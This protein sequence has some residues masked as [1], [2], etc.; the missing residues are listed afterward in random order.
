MKTRLFFVI[1]FVIG[2]VLLATLLPAS[3]ISVSAQG[4]KPTVT[5]RR[6][7][8]PQPPPVSR[9]RRINPSQ[10]KPH[11]A[12]IVASFSAGDVFAGVA[13]GQ[14]NWY[15]A[16]GVLAT[17]LDTG[18]G[19]FTTGMAFDGAG[20]LYVTNFSAGTVSKFD[21]SGNYL[22]IFGSG[23]SGSPESIVFDGAGNAY[24]GSVD[25]DDAI[26]KFDPAGNPLSQYY[27]ATETRGSDWIDLA[28]DQCTMYYTSEGVTVKRFNV[29]TNTQLSD[30]ASG[31]YGPDY[32][33]RILADGSVLIADT[34]QIVRLDSSG[35]IIQTYS[36]NGENCWF[37]LN[38]DPDGT[39]FWS[40]D[41][42]TGDIYRFDIG[43][44]TILLGPLSTCGSNCL[45]GLAIA[46]EIKAAT[47]K[48]HLP[49]DLAFSTS[50][51]DGTD[52]IYSYFDHQYPLER[53]DLGGTEPQVP[54]I[55]D[56][57]MIFTGQTYLDCWTQ[58]N[59]SPNN[60]R[61]Y[62]GHDGYDFSG[63][64][65]VTPVY[66]A[67]DGI[68]VAT[69]WK[70]SNSTNINVMTVTKGDVQTIYL[71]LYT[72]TYWSKFLSNPTQVTAGTR[73]G[74]IG[75]T[76]APTCSKG[77][78]LHFGV[79]YDADH[80]GFDIND[81][82]DPYSFPPN[83]TDPWTQSFQDKNGTW[84]TGTPSP[85]M[86]QFGCPASGEAGPGMSRSLSTGDA[87]VSVTS[88]ALNSFAL[89]A[90]M[91]SP[92]PLSSQTSSFSPSR[93]P[94]TTNTI[95]IGSVYQFSGTYGDG[96]PVAG[97]ASAAPLTLTY[98]NSDLSY[99]NPSTLSIYQWGG[100]NTGWVSVPT[101]VN[102]SVNQAN[103]NLSAPGLFSLRAQ[104]INPAP[105]LLSVSPSSA[106]NSRPT[107]ITITGMNFMSTPW[108]NLGISAL[109]VQF[110]SP[111]TLQATVPAFMS[112]GVNTLTLRDPDG[113]F[114][115]LPNAF[116]VQTSIYMPFIRK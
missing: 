109:N 77:A 63:R 47:L 107:I 115:S 58:S 49:F 31:L 22:G 86:W 95:G 73:I 82:I 78:H 6:D 84:H 48:F 39:S 5:P 7:W 59:N 3:S 50:S 74:T 60:C 97:F 110:V 76:G 43:T 10:V 15:H 11:R 72:D 55:N 114:I 100:S 88:N 101:N 111:T 68:A 52:R 42:C 105:V 96:T 4:P 45:Y 18:L 81:K 90:L 108:V 32:A 65:G 54:G 2:L 41:H 29:C 75:N 23:Y 91:I 99:V 12:S 85:C 69:Q 79:Y 13:N 113:Q 106:D 93:L 62:S 53:P 67:H 71:H 98:A 20:N 92:D 66:A 116:T 16:N 57:I 24:V 9:Q 80:N 46:R 64:E 94:S 21:T 28:A 8:S 33:L 1:T 102:A 87:N 38:L 51:Q 34:V 44:G 30:F 40:G 35:Q 36:A 103:T 61:W 37:A 104:P 26:R 19:G 25:G 56:T 27:V 83:L 70:C 14:V 112:P 89:L 17:T